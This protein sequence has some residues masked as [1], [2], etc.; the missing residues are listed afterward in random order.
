LVKLLLFIKIIITIYYYYQDHSDKIKT[1]KHKLKYKHHLHFNTA[2]WWLYRVKVR[3]SM[4][5]PILK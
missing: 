4:D 3:K 5:N 1:T 2:Y